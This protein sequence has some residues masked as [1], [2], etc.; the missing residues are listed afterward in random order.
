MA[1]FEITMAKYKIIR[2]DWFSHEDSTEGY[3]DSLEEA[4]NALDAIRAKQASQPEPKDSYSLY[5]IPQDGHEPMS[6]A[7]W[8]GIEDYGHHGIK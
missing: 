3:Y 4:R 5:E 6:Y 1:N 8:L 7:E 2:E